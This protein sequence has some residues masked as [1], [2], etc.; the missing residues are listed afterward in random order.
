MLTVGC[1][2]NNRD[3]CGISSRA[4]PEHEARGTRG[5]LKWDPV[6]T[7]RQHATQT[8]LVY[9]LFQGIQT[10]FESYGE[11]VKRVVE[12]Y[13]VATPWGEMSRRVPGAV[14]KCSM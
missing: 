13:W 11:K 6:Y 9:K 8:L 10:K 2:R 1:R 5:S 7:N 3:K 4:Y 14:E 12:G